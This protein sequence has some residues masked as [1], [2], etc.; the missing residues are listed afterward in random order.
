LQLSSDN[1]TPGS[2]PYSD[3]VDTWADCSQSLFKSCSYNV[4]G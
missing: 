4:G 2:K 1:C 3:L